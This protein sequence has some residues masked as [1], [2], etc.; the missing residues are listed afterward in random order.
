MSEGRTRVDLP[1]TFPLNVR[2]PDA[3]LVYLD[4][5]HW[6]SLSKWISGHKDGPRYKT[7]FDACT[8]A[9]N[10]G[11]AEFLISL[12][13]IMEIDAIRNRQQ[14]LWLRKVLERVSRFRAV[15]PRDVIAALEFEQ[16][17]A[18]Q[19]VNMRLR[20]APLDYVGNGVGWASGLRFDPSVIDERGRDVTV[21]TFS[22]MPPGLRMFVAPKYISDWMTK[23][24]IEGPANL[25]EEKELRTNG[26]SP[27]GLRDLFD[28]RVRLETQLVSDFDERQARESSA[29]NWRKGRLR[30]VVSAR[31]FLHGAFEIFTAV[32]DQQELTL[33]DVFDM[34]GTP[35][36]LRHNRRITD[37]M[38][39]FDVA[40]TLKASYH[41]NPCHPWRRNDIFDIDAMS[42]VLPYC[43]VVVTDRAMASHIEQNKLARRL[44]T[45]VLASLDDLAEQ[46]AEAR[47]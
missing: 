38:P 27:E 46:L 13:L 44:N 23:M 4:L 2:R 17:L 30:D 35:S 42:T 33:E 11:H 3:L 40:V 24:I 9:V 36:A 6:I 43:D 8:T 10:E 37:A 16:V 5:N 28:E 47:S 41:R 45:K 32:L 15:L 29:V 7:V 31:Q 21:E 22:R 26:W 25:S 1:Y 34:S 20:T 39:T 19:L 18:S 12:P 14:R